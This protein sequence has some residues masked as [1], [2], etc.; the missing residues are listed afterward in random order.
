MPGVRENTSQQDEIG[1][2]K[3]PITQEGSVNFQEKGKLK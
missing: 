2:V 1:L 3:R